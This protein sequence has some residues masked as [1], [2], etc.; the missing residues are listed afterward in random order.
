MGRLA[1]CVTLFFVMALTGPVHGKGTFLADERLQAEVQRGFEKILD[2][3]RDGRYEELYD[4][5]Y[6]GS[7]SRERFGEKM[8]SAPRRPACCWEKMQ[9]VKV[10]VSREG[11][12]TLRA[13]IGL[14]GAGNGE[15]VT[16]SFRLL[17]EEGE[18]KASRQDILSLAAA[19][20]R[21]KHHNKW[22]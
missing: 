1:L 6:G 13:R 7:E 16:R 11:R 18:W 20:K 14:E 15:S 9:E 2:F 10:N 3:W 21:K 4:R 19:S 12:A 5:T 22:N 8:S 17:F